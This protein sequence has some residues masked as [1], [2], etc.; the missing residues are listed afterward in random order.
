MAQC[1]AEF[2]N[3]RDANK[4]A[5]VAP[6]RGCGNVTVSGKVVYFTLTDAT[7]QRMNNQAPKERIYSSNMF[8]GY[9][10][11]FKRNK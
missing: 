8:G 10:W 3:S 2:T 9:D 6:S 5:S 11:L 4:W 7:V 1:S